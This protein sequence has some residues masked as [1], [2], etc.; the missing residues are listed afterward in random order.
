[1][2]R[3]IERTVLFADLRGSTAL[4]HSLGN[5][6]AT[7]VVTQCVQ[8]LTPAVS[9]AGGR[10]V[11]TLGDGL[12]AVYDH[13]EHGVESASRLHDAMTSMIQ[14]D[15]RG[16]RPAGMRV[17]HLQVALAHGEVIEMQDD[18][19][20][21]AVNVAARML[22]HAG[23]D[24]TLI[25]HATYERLHPMTQSLYRRLDPIVLR[26]RPEPLVIHTH[27]RERDPDVPDER[28][29]IFGGGVAELADGPDTVLL[30]CA[31]T[32][33]AFD[34]HAMPAL[35]GRSRQSHFAIDDTRV[36][37]THARIDWHGG[38]FQL[39]DL[40][41][42]GTVVDFRGGEVIALRRGSC[43]L[44]GRGHIGLG[45]I[46]G[47]EDAVT[48]AFEV[49]RSGPPGLGPDEDLPGHFGAIA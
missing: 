25:T 49:Y 16:P 35:L 32:R 11:K 15:A 28:S 43:T 4:F 47:D 39:T 19:F 38:A 27:G 13:P 8:R 29:T 9:S 12:M 20:G 26:G 30:A 34:R 14:A 41:Y 24:E 5:A 3:L 10:M 46:P 44:L 40:S 36:S 37:R 1:M 48:V 21:D 6:A 17:L 23:D 2:P 22:E 42:N 18:C 31:S 33:R 7:A 45:G